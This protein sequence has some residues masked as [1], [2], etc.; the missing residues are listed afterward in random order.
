MHRN[1]KKTEQPSPLPNQMT[2]RKAVRSKRAS[3]AIYIK[4]TP[5]VESYYK[6]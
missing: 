3:V 1:I 2:P 5:I 4:K 6:G